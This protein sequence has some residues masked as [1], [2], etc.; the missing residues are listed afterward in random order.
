VIDR[1]VQRNVVV[2]DSGNNR[3]QVVDQDGG[4]VRA[5]GRQGSGNGEFNR[6][7]AVALDPEGNIFVVDQGN[8]RVQS[9]SPDGQFLKAFGRQGDGPGE[10]ANPSGIAI[11]DD[12][13]ITVVDTDNH[14]L[15]LFVAANQLTQNA[16]PNRASGK[17]EMKKRKGS[18]GTTNRAKR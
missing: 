4:F 2:A 7:V 9:F 8:N 1:T 13:F 12:G 3:I 11:D 5:F 10:F 6:P 15:Q 16:L 18:K 14:R 17:A